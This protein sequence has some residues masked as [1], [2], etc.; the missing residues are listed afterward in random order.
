M[1]EIVN[2]VQMIYDQFN[3]EN[4]PRIRK[5]RHYPSSLCITL[6]GKFE[7]KCRRATVYSM[8]NVEVSNPIDPVSLFKMDMGNA[9]HDHVNSIMNRALTRVYKDNFEMVGVEED[10]AEEAF[11]WNVKGLKLPISGRMDKIVKINGKNIVFEWK[12]TYMSG[13]KSIQQYGAKLDHILQGL[14]YIEQDVFPVDGLV[15]M[16]IARDTGYLYGF[17]IEKEGK[18]LLMHHMNSDKVDVLKINFNLVKKELKAI[19]KH[20]KNGTIPDRDYEAFVNP[21]LNK[22]MVKSDWHCRYCSYRGLCYGC[23]G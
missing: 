11:L 4:E 5:E 22:L 16:Y 6:D 19:E 18:T 2:T 9:I 20:L 1:G 8:R 13:V 14:A 3:I 10:G 12:S 7:G 23:E 21:K 17:Y 15:I